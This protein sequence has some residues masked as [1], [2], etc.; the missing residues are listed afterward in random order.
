MFL[1]YVYLVIFKWVTLILPL[2]LIFCN[3]SCAFVFLS[4][5]QV[6]HL[7]MQIL[8]LELTVRLWTTKIHLPFLMIM[9][10]QKKQK[11][12]SVPSLLTGKQSKHWIYLS[13]CYSFLRSI[14]EHLCLKYWNK[15]ATISK[16]I[17]DSET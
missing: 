15:N 1:V 16:I 13:F 11:I 10:Y 2:K 7:F 14:S 5:F 17:Y 12:L 8:W 3:V 6:I 4:N 9:T